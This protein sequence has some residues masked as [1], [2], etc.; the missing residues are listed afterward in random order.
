MRHTWMLIC[1]LAALVACNHPTPDYVSTYAPPAPMTPTANVAVIGDSYA[2]GS[3][4]GNQ[5]WPAVVAALLQEQ[6]INVDMQIAGP[7]GKSRRPMNKQVHDAVGPTT[8][9]V[10]LFGS[11]NN[12]TS[13]AVDLSSGVSSAM[14]EA[15]KISSNARFLLIG[16]IWLDDTPP[17]NVLTAR[18]MLRADA[19][20][21]GAAFID[22]IGERWFTDQPN[23]FGPNMI[24]DEAGHSYMAARMAPLIAEQLRSTPINVPAALPPSDQPSPPR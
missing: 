24:L 20:A 1:L 8:K 6:N 10:V 3:T 9:L 19:E 13:P 18:V 17:Q 12:S 16:P 5:A 7:R 23:L 15:K 14:A 21:A 2:N 22:P 4:D 11:L